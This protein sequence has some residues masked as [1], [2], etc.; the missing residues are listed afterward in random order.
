METNKEKQIER[1]DS[2][3]IVQGNPTG[4]RDKGGYPIRIGD[5][6]EWDDAEGK[7]TAEVIYENGEVGFHC[8]KNS[9]PNWAIGHKF[10]IGTFMYKD[11]EH[12]LIIIKNWGERARE[13]YLTLSEEGQARHSSQA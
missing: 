3:Y 6:V 2:Y 13:G 11:T 12:N 10:M 9:K 1:E 7:R 5:I 4:L 8:F